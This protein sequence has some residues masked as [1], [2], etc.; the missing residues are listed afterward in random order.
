[1]Q[2]YPDELITAERPLNAT[3]EEYEAL[4]AALEVDP[5]EQEP[6]G[7]EIGYHEGKVYIFAYSDFVWEHYPQAFEDLV[8][9]LIAKNGLDHLDFRGGLKG[10]I[11]SHDS[12]VYFQIM[13]DGS[14][15]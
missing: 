6:S 15:R 8:R 7:W 2:D 14:L 11:V 1:M 9:A 12:E 3:R 13:T 5:D 4:K 10:P